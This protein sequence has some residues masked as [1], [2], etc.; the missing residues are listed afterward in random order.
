MNKE[1]DFHLS[2]Q[3]G[4]EFK[5]ITAMIDLYCEKHHQINTVKFQRCA[6]CE[7]F[8]NYV[9]QRLDR[10]PY[11][12]NKPSCKQCPIHCYKPQQKV[13][14][15]TIMRYS[16]PKMIIKHPIMAIKHLIHDKRAIPERNKE[17]L[18][19]YQKRKTLLNNK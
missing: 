16:G 11:G 15:Q 6:D 3:L 8:R 19:N 17:I 7:Q 14:S 1:T 18:S 2:G 10:C 4:R 13:H 9:K 5:T 12:E